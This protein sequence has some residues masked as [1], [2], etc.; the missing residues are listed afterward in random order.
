MFG[1]F[2]R[3]L[4]SLDPP[5]ADITDDAGKGS[6]VT[7]ALAVTLELSAV[8]DIETAGLQAGVERG[9]RA[10]LQPRAARASSPR[11]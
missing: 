9:G 7:V 10:G 2:V 3:Y 6:G 1:D 4:D 8:R 5:V 11:R